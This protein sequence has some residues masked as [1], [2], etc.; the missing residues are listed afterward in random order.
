MT[1]PVCTTRGCGSLTAYVDTT[2]RRAQAWIRV[3]PADQPH[4]AR[5][6]CTA[7]CAAAALA[8]GPAEVE[9]TVREALVQRIDAAAGRLGELYPGHP[10]MLARRHGLETA[11]RIVAPDEP[12]EAAARCWLCGCT[13]D[14]ACAG[15]CSWIPDPT[16]IRDMCWHCPDPDEAGEP[17]RTPGCGTTEDLDPS[18]PVAVGWI[19]LQ[20]AGTGGG[21][22]WYCNP[23]CVDAAI[24]R[25]AAE[26]AAEDTGT[27]AEV[28][29]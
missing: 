23:W 6:Y 19:R 12:D 14:D 17:C 4:E 21:P 5:W 8:G 13:E 27:P 3:Q 11:R 22:R 28:T 10:L 7:A 9:R 20:V 26:L 29:R 16:G 25:A 2:T 15:G 24:A 1:A 18:D